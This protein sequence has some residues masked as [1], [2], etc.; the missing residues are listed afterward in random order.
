[1]VLSLAST[2]NCI[3]MDDELNILPTSSL[4]KDIQP[5]AAEGE[6][7]PQSAA[8]A[9]L[10]ELVE[11]LKGTEASAPPPPLPPLG[12]FHHLRCHRYTTLKRCCAQMLK[13]LILNM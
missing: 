10:A 2:P 9:E 1:M 4:V 5:L 8:T 6:G 11:S 13:I 3:M 12:L 7:G